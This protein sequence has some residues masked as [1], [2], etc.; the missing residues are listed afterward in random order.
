M[1]DKSVKLNDVLNDV[2]ENNTKV[3]VLIDLLKR[4]N[5]LLE[6]QKYAYQGLCCALLAKEADKM[7]QKGEYIQ[8]YSKYINKS[9]AMN[10]NCYEARLF[11]FLVEKGLSSVVFVSHFEEDKMFLTENIQKISDDFL[12]QL[13]HKS[14]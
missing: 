5:L 9:L 2:L 13:T 10:T 4:D 12:I 3:G 8:A 11:R 7:L 6:D 14:I 1:T